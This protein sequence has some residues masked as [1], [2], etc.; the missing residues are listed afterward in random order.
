MFYP[1]NAR[2]GKNQKKLT[3]TCRFSTMHIGL[4]RCGGFGAPLLWRCLFNFSPR[5]SNQIG[6][7]NGDE[8]RNGI[9]CVKKL[10]FRYCK[11]WPQ[12][13]ESTAT[14]V[15]SCVGEG[16]AQEE[17]A[18]GE[19]AANTTTACWFAPTRGCCGTLGHN[20]S[21]VGCVTSACT[22]S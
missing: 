1:N 9:C 4:G 2:H 8:P 11:K 7:E 5:S 14:P 15:S 6:S 10:P 19:G 13:A 18:M 16:S 21:T 17:C 12:N 20:V 22:S 3:S